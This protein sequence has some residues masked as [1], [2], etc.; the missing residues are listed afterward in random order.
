ML[1]LRIAL[2]YLLSRKSHKAVNVISAISLGGV[3]VATMAII[4][5]LSV[6]NGFS[7]LA[8]SRLSRITAP[9]TVVPATGKVLDNA[10]EL[11]QQL[12]ALPA[13]SAAVE[14]LEERALAVSATAQMPVRVLGVDKSNF[15]KV[16]DVD[17]L[18]SQGSFSAYDD[19][20]TGVAAAALSPGVGVGLHMFGAQYADFDLY[21]PRRRGRINPANPAGAYRKAHMYASGIIEVEQPDYDAD[22]IYMELDTL[23][24][25]LDYT[26]RQAGSIALMPADGVSPGEAI[27]QVRGVL[28]EGLNV[29][30]AD[31]LSADTY[32]MI[33]IEK[34]VTFLMLVFILLIA[35]FNI[36]STLSLM[37]IEKRKDMVT[38]RAL[39]ATHGLAAGVFA[40]EGWLITATGGVLGAVIGV[41]LVLMQQTWGFVK[42]ASGTTTL[43]IDA[44][45][46]WLNWGDVAAVLGA[47]MAVGALIALISK[48]FTRKF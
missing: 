35:S 23:R 22:M 19:T 10:S 44:Y 45:P 5:V 25:L 1:S 26:A 37:V 11:K 6:F 2:R 33:A 27:T 34:W 43:T 47:V 18:L 12:E 41:V 20:V 24:R 48:I 9:L 15:G 16:A 39:G 32:K 8:H 38:L 13:I 4:V 3:A 14:Q 7:R 28:P 42:L 29:L 17:A 30:T 46:V 21:V 40:W 36:V 31:Q